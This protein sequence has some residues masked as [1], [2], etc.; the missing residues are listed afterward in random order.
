M[1]FNK[2]EVIKMIGIGI[3]A[4][5]LIFGAIAVD[6]LLDKRS[7]ESA[8]GAIRTVYVVETNTWSSDY[9]TTL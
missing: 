2:L 4:V 9:I 5:I 7:S 8:S 6:T 3:L 1:N